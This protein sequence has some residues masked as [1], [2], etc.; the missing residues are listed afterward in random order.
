MERTTLRKSSMYLWQNSKLGFS[1]QSACIVKISVKPTNY[2][3]LARPRKVI[4]T[5][6]RFE[7]SEIV[8]IRIGRA[9]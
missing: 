2:D 8:W 9:W 5:I 3:T 7:P 6:I 1:Y 4:V